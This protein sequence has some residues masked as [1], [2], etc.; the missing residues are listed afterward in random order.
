LTLSGLLVQGI[1]AMPPAD[2][3]SEDVDPNA[4]VAVR[5]FRRGASIYYFCHAY[6]VRRGQTG[7]PQIESELRLFREGVLLFSSGPQPIRD[8]RIDRAVPAAGTLYLSPDLATGNYLLE[9][10]LT[11]RLAKKHHR[12]TQTIDFEVVE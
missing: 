1:N 4:T 3:T 12:S 10:T 7:Q 8:A 2:G 11:D 9:L 6:N 5:R